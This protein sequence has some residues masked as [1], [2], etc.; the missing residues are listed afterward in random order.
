MPGGDVAGLRAT[1]DC[2][3]MHSYLKACLVPSEYVTV[4]ASYV[5]S[6]ERE[7]LTFQVLAVDLQDRH[8]KTYIDHIADPVLP[9]ASVQVLSE[10]NRRSVHRRVQM[11]RDVLVVQDPHVMDVL[12][13]VGTVDPQ[14]RKCFTQWQARPSDVEGCVCLHSPAPLRCKIENHMSPKVPV[15]GLLD[16]LGDDW[17]GVPNCKIFLTTHC[18]YTT[19]GGCRPS[20]DSV[21]L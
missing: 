18:K 21:I 8:V 19:A 7:E 20:G 1:D 16:I 4:A 13:L 14:D 17:S 5:E 10:F 9:P 11:V 3:L 15:L 6:E 2:K 12:G